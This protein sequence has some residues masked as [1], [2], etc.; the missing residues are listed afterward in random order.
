MTS[1]PIC[2]PAD[3]SVR[4]LRSWADLIGNER[5]KKSALKIVQYPGI[6]PK[7]FVAG[8]PG[9]GKSCTINHACRWAACRN[10]QGDEPCGS[11]PGCRSFTASHRDAGLFSYLRDVD[12][13]CPF[14]Y[15]PINCRNTTPAQIHELLDA[16][17]HLEGRRHIHL[18][19]SGWPIPMRSAFFRRMATSRRKQAVSYFAATLGYRRRD[20]GVS[21]R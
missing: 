8:P 12:N 16:I 9:S 14:H 11:C 1:A 3:F 21:M 6:P 2:S 7:M 18:E 10:P 5:A 19:E 4:Q 17:K 13:P 20:W 15:L